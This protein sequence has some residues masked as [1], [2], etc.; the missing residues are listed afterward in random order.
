M[1]RARKNNRP[2]GGREMTSYFIIAIVPFL[3]ML[4]AIRITNKDYASPLFLAPCAYFI[5]SLFAIIGLSSWNDVS[6]LSAKTV[7][8]ICVALIA[9]FFGSLLAKSKKKKEGAVKTLSMKIPTDTNACF[10]MAAIAVVVL[11]AVLSIINIRGTCALIGYGN[12][13]LPEM[14][15]IYRDNTSL[16]SA[17][18]VVYSSLLNSVLPKMLIFIDALFSVYS[19]V[20]ACKKIHN[21]PIKITELLAM[22]SMLAVSF[23][24]S[25]RSHF[26]KMIMIYLVANLV[27]RKT[28]DGPK[29]KKTKLYK[30]IP[31]AA[32][33]AIVF[34][35]SLAL[36]GRQTRMDFDSYITFYYGVQVPSLDKYLEKRDAGILETQYE[37]RTFDS[38]KGIEEKLGIIENKKATSLEFVHYKNGGGSNIYTSVRRPYDD[39]GLIGLVI[40]MALFGYIATRLYYKAIGTQSISILVFY[41]IAVLD[42]TIDQ[43]RDLSFYIRFFGISIIIY[44]LASVV[45][46]RV[47]RYYNEKYMQN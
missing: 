30:I 21:R 16:F 6:V 13:S 17:K 15:S 27:V 29:N 35:S 2:Q 12:L 25:G 14:L 4:L 47:F 24:T 43:V 8:L 39:F 1:W 41:L 7:L 23:L 34:Y 33:I 19:I 32:I 20:I 18:Q 31:I 22:F 9:F 36:V 26:V 5:M 10:N 42:T 3:L 11:Y 38:L 45:M 46:P 28:I 44:L 40:L 37:S